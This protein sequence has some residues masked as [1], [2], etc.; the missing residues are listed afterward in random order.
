MEMTY[1]MCNDSDIGFKDYQ[2]EYLCSCFAP[3]NPD[4]WEEMGMGEAK[5]GTCGNWLEIVRPGKYQC[6]PCEVR[7][8]SE[9]YAREK[10]GKEYS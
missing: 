9:R 5:C 2:I 10:L 6:V 7:E 4:I 8:Q 1:S 3:Q